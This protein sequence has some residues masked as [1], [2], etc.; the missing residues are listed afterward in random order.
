MNRNE[1]KAAVEKHIKECEVHVRGATE[2]TPAYRFAVAQLTWAYI[3]RSAVNCKEALQT[4]DI[5]KKEVVE[6]RAARIEYDFT[7]CSEDA[8]DK[9]ID[10]F[11][12]LRSDMDAFEK[13]HK[14]QKEA[15]VSTLS[16]DL[17]VESE[18]VGG[19]LSILDD[20]KVEKKGF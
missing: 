18:D 20:L 6:G 9:L 2:A 13:H 8:I 16:E 1:L 11:Q 3:L 4:H 7:E 19:L 14:E 10:V 12:K 5:P 17:K 15:I